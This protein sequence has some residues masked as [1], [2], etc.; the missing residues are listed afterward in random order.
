MATRTA[1]KWSMFAPQP[2]VKDGWIVTPGQFKDGIERDLLRV[3]LAPGPASFD[4]PDPVYKS[5]MGGGV[6]WT[7]YLM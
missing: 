6:R 7:K 2:S 4:K 5:F 1:Q 3:P